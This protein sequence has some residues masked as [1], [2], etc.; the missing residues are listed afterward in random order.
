MAYSIRDDDGGPRRNVCLSILIEGQSMNV[1]DIALE[2][3]IL[4]ASGVENRN[5]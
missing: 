4:R 1:T 5:W 3:E 2:I